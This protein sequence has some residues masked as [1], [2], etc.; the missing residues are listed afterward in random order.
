M[1]SLTKLH[2]HG[3]SGRLGRVIARLARES[4]RFEVTGSGREGNL[5]SLVN[6]SDVVIDVSQPDSSILIVDSCV[7]NQK[8]IAI[9]TTGHSAEQLV[10]LRAAANRIP[11]L[12]APNFSV[13][14]NLLFWL[15]QQTAAVLG[16]DFDAEIVEMHHRLKKD[17]PSGTAKRLAEL[18]AD[19]WNLDYETAGRHGRKGIVGER[20]NG[21]I[22]LHA[23]RG[24]DVVGEHTVYFTGLGERIELTHRATNREIFAAG[25][26]RAAGWLL[27]QPPGWYDM[28]DCL[29]LG[30]FMV[31]GS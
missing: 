21:E 28:Q 6:A 11:I 17:A 25:S 24:G 13:G 5:D 14:V 18:V 27:A 4:G 3:H 8:P 9:G 10:K 12:L 26:L 22:G 16:P 29:G 2:L 19:S 15:T 31:H 23:V 30:K 1:S 7:K 20:T